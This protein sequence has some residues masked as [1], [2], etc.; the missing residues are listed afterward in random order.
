M[1]ARDVFICILLGW[2]GQKLTHS[3]RSASFFR[4]QCYLRT[5]DLYQLAK[6]L[7]QTDDNKIA[8]KGGRSLEAN[9]IEGG[10]S[11]LFCGVSCLHHSAASLFEV[12]LSAFEGM[13][14]D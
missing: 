11:S 7:G 10:R 5:I 3:H 13:L 6:V 1:H 14:W 8:G 9:K 4:H 12:H 2:V